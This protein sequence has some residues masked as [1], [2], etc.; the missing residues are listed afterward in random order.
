MIAPIAIDGIAAAFAAGLASS[1]HCALMCGP[2]GCAVLGAG[3]PGS[4][5]I[6]A[7]AVYHGARLLAY[8][9]IGALAGGVGTAGAEAFNWPIARTL[10]WVLAAL[11]VIF[12]LRLQRWLPKPLWLGRWH[13]QLLVTT[14]NVPS[15]LLGGLLGLATPLLPCGPLYVLFTVALFTGSAVRG[16][17]LTLAFGLGT[18]PLLWLAQAGLARWQIRLSPTLWR[19]TQSIVALSAAIIVAWR[20]S[21]GGPGWLE[22]ICH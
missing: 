20:A 13:H 8:G 19:R 9:T 21:V 15:S 22:A 3:R 14:R 10:P 2:L 16:A 1:P 7:R 12:A 5:T 4:M 6:P 11:L 18:L 17:T